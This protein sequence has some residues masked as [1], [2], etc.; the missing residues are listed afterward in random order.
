[1]SWRD[2]FRHEKDRERDV[3]LNKL[4]RLADVTEQRADR[5]TAEQKQL[6]SALRNTVKALRAERR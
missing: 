6:V 4:E 2:L 1:M 3:E 5:V